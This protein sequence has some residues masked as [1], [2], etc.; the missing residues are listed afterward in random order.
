MARLS[1]H[2]PGPGRSGATREQ[3]VDVA[4]TQLG[5]LAFEDLLKT[6]TPELLASDAPWAPSTVRYQFG[7]RRTTDES[8]RRLAFRRRELALSMLEAALAEPAS[9]A[10]PPGAEGP[11]SPEA[12]PGT[13]E[14]GAVPGPSSRAPERPAALLLQVALAVCDRDPDVAR[15]LREARDRRISRFVEEYA[16]ILAARGTKL[17]PGRTLEQLGAAIDAV[18]DGRRSH[19]RFA[20]DGR[21]A[22]ADAV[23]AIVAAFTVSRTDPPSGGDGPPL[24]RPRPA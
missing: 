9:P 21:A 2:R 6:L 3:I 23:S 12:L 14:P 10:F 24:V 22:A 4:L 11:S 5:G 13:H 18:D 15:L 1:D 8:R 7:D 20:P 19:A 17:R 16:P